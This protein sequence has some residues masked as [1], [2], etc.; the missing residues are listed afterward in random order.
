MVLKKEIERYI[1]AAFDG[2]FVV[3]L[4]GITPQELRERR[5]NDCMFIEIET[6]NKKGHFEEVTKIMNKCK[7]DL[8]EL[9]INLEVSEKQI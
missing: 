6:I 8:S 2:H 5:F 9:G 3:P 1:K 7:E 4:W